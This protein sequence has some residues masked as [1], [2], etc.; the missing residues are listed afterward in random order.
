[1]A[2]L[3]QLGSA[4]QLAVM[5]PGIFKAQKGGERDAA[6]KSVALV[7]SRIDNEDER[8]TQLIKA[9]DAVEF[10]ERDQLLSLV[11]RVGGE[12]LIDFVG[13]IATGSDAER[14]KLGID[15]LRA[16]SKLRRLATS[17]MIVSVSI[18]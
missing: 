14:R 1:M 7:C 9:L 17:G 11:G 18:A 5:L 15:A 8:G 16:T 2:A 3:G 4:G 13:Q 10:D 6:E 12:K